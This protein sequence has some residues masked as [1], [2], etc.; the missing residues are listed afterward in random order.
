MSFGNNQLEFL[1][2]ILENALQPRLLDSH[3]WTKS[4]IVR[5][6]RT[7]MSELQEKSPGEKLVS[8]I[9]ELFLQM[10]PATPPRHG[11]RLDTR[12]GEFGM[13]AAE[14]FAPLVFGETTPASLRE[15]WGHIDQSILLF[16]FGKT[17][18]P[19]TDKEKDPYKLV[20]NELEI[21]PN[22]TLSDWHRNALER[23]LKIILQRE[24]YLSSTLNKP[25]VISLTDQSMD[26][27][28][29]KAG[30]TRNMRH[31]SRL[32]WYMFFI[33][34]L[35]LLG[36][37]IFGGVKGWQIYKQAMLVRQ[38]ALQLRNTISVSGIKLD[39]I[40]AVGP[41]LNS[42]SKD[43]G[44]LKNESEPFLWICPLLSWVPVYG[45]DIA[46]V[47][48]LMTMADDLLSSSNLAYQ[49]LTP[50]LGGDKP[51]VINLAHISE[52]FVKFQPQMIEAQ[53]QIS[54]EEFVRG[55]LDTD[56]CQG[57]IEMSPDCAK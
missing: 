51:S 18:H 2:A 34:A 55:Q 57:L 14:Y 24:N 5:Q 50:L 48:P 41:T 52:V 29:T 37:V 13:L 44:T 4:L 45:G 26:N 36:S 42:L 21:A 23:L 16:V 56:K 1:R 46:Y 17:D 11:K 39:Q 53:Q 35:V 40:K 27:V 28:L 22:S 43:F 10:M 31:S 15:A 19:L 8:M 49:V 47:K 54:Q 6:V 33:I 38:D 9:S 12:W 30:V 25:A 3:P 20:G 7:D 32:R